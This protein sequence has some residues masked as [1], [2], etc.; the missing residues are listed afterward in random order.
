MSR[1]A[2]MFA[3]ILMAVQ[4]PVIAYA[5]GADEFDAMIADERDLTRGFF[6]GIIQGYSWSNTTL[7]E[8]NNEMLYCLPEDRVSGLELART[9]AAVG[10]RLLPEEARTP[11]KMPLAVLLGLMA[12]F[13]C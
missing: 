12:M 5:Q 3:F 2:V 9:A 6:V 7:S 11:E 10:G 13:P 8:K 1:N 4:A